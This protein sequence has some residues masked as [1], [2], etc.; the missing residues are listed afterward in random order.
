MTFSFR[1][2]ATEIEFAPEST[3][4]SNL[5][6]HRRRVVFLFCIFN[7]TVRRFP[8]QRATHCATDIFP[9]ALSFSFLEKKLKSTGENGIV[10]RDG[11]S[12]ADWYY[13]ETWIIQ[14]RCYN[15]F[16]WYTFRNVRQH[17]QRRELVSERKLNVWTRNAGSTRSR[18]DLDGEKRKRVDISLSCSLSWAL[19]NYFI[20]HLSRAHGHGNND[21]L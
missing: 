19:R 10:G 1:S 16:P 14:A 21:R 20:S 12:I 2:F 5:Y 4:L 6:I 17:C 9:A 8:R 18:H 15:V 3:K 11:P 7:G 13:R